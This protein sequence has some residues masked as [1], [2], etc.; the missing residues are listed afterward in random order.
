MLGRYVVL[1]TLG[2]GGMGT[3][4]EAFDRTLDRRVAIK[5]LHQ[6]LDDKHTARLLREARAMAKLSHP[7]VVPVFEA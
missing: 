5:V 6:N 2:Q 4:L 3:V 7:N 1:G